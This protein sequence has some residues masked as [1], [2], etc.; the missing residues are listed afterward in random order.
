MVWIFLCLPALGLPLLGGDM[1]CK[2]VLL[3]R[4][5]ILGG[6]QLIHLSATMLTH[7]E[8]RSVEKF[9]ML[10]KYGGCLGSHEDNA[11]HR[12]HHLPFPS[13]WQHI[14]SQS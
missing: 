14:G 6:F 13:A 8:L 1:Q 2:D 3:W 4:N 9:F 7:W 5:K 10:S 11:Q 12:H